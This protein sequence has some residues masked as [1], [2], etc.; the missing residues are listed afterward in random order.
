MLPYPLESLNYI[1]HKV[2]PCKVHEQLMKRYCKPWYIVKVEPICSFSSAALHNPCQNSDCEVEIGSYNIL[3]IAQA[4][5]ILDIL[6]YNSHL[7]FLSRVNFQICCCFS[8]Y[9][10]RDERGILVMLQN[11]L[12]FCLT[13]TGALGKTYWKHLFSFCAGRGVDLKCPVAS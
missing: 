2:V 9:A 4:M 8:S 5:G 13:L 12:A 10:K 11:Q 3:F 6:W 7:F 1:Q